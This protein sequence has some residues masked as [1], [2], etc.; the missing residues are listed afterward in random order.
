MYYV[1]DEP[2]VLREI[3]LDEWARIFEHTAGRILA[4]DV[5]HDGLVAVSTVWMGIDHRHSDDGPPL[6]YETMVFHEHAQA[7][8]I[9][10]Y[11][12]RYSYRD[13]ALRGHAVALAWA[14]AHG[15]SAGTGAA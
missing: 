6:I 8:I 2:G 11:Q 14:I 7:P 4:I 12:T 15:L 1:E 5:I 10:E 9:G 3:G 13:D